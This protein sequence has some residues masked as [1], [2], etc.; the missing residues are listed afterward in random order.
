M[1]KPLRISVWNAN[2]LC[3]HAQELPHFLQLFDIDILL[4]SETHFTDRSYIKVPNYIIYN[5]LHPDETAHGGTAII[6]RRNI[7]HHIREGYKQEHIQATSIA[8]KD[9]VGE[10]TSPQFTVPPSIPLK[11]LTT[12]GSS[13]R[14]DIDSLREEITML[15]T[16]HGEQGSQQPKEGSY[17]TLWATTTCNTYRRANPH[18]G[19]MTRTDNQIYWTSA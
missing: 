10:L 7:K 18:S 14:L 8:L 19:Q 6:I 13:T 12:Q 1:A 4:I 15:K 9:E 11:R 5:T 2:G 16:R 3:K 17:I